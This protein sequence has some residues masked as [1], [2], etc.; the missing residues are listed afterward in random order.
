MSTSW[1]TI[2]YGYSDP[3]GYIDLD[4]YNAAGDLWN[5]AGGLAV[6]T[7]KDEAAGIHLML[8]A[9]ASVTKRRARGKESI[10]NLKSYLYTAYKNLLWKELK[11]LRSTE[12]QD[13]ERVDA[14]VAMF[15]GGTA[16]ADDFAKSIE[17]RILVDQIVSLMDD[18]TREVYDFLV[19]GH[20]FKDIARHQGKRSNFIRS[21]YSKRI[22]RLVLIMECGT[23]ATKD[24]NPADCAPALERVR[25]PSR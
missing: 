9:A 17:R 14:F 8:K 11:R 18:W 20:N 24:R 6:I 19:L 4:V 15:V 3:E 1:P 7:L 23:A 5:M 12:P 16:P 2:D 13:D 25:G 10:E 21:K 22:R